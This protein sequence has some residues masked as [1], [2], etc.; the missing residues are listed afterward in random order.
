MS[1]LHAYSHNCRYRPIL[2]VS[3]PKS[4]SSCYHYVDTFVRHKPD[5]LRSISINE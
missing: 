1:W 3:H 4:C 2:E 5:S